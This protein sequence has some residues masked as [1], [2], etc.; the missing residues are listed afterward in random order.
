MKKKNLSEI[1]GNANRNNNEISSHICQNGYYQEHKQH[2]LVRIWR[3]ENP[4][5]LSLCL[6]TQS[7]PTLCNPMDCSPP[8]SSVHGDFPGK[9]T[10]VGCHFL[11]Q[12]IFLTEGSNLLSLVFCTGRQVL[13][14][15]CPLPLGSPLPAC[16]MY[17]K[18]LQWCLILC[19]PMD[20]GLPGP[21][22]H[23]TLQARTLEWVA[24]SFSLHASHPFF[25]ELEVYSS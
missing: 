17:A 12:G 20:C 6:V 8:G 18:S 4:C 2:M 9:N 22:T 1:Q 14:H 15:Q 3:K 7:C 23:G 21:S 5:A 16:S 10:R 19:N 11:L 13:Y 24:I 25:S